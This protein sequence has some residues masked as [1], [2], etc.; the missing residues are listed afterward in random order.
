MYRTKYTINPTQPG[1]KVLQ[2]ANNL[3][4]KI[5]FNLFIFHLNCII[6]AFIIDIKNI[7]F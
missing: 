4:V 5:N 6:I 1:T 7:Y 2:K 3:H